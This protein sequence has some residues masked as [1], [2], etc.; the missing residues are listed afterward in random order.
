M[1]KL[2]KVRYPVTP[3][4]DWFH[5]KKLTKKLS[6]QTTC[7]KYLWHCPWC[8]ASAALVLCPLSC[9]LRPRRNCLICIWWWCQEFRIFLHATCSSKWQEGITEDANLSSQLVRRSNSLTSTRWWD[10]GG[11]KRGGPWKTLLFPEVGFWDSGI[12]CETRAS[13]QLFPCGGGCQG[14]LHHQWCTPSR[15]STHFSACLLPAYCI[16]VLRS[17][18]MWWRIAK[19]LPGALTPSPGSRRLQITQ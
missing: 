11:R 19:H 15:T 7:S 12:N 9:A 10:Q 3:L 4:S 2:P 14:A 8:V 5:V 1:D 16:T 6:S 13:G 17:H 18:S